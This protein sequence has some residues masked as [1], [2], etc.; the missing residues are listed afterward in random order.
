MAT[1]AARQAR[2]SERAQ[3]ARE[4]W[5]SERRRSAAHARMADTMY[6]STPSAPVVELSCP[7]VTSDDVRRAVLGWGD[8]VSSSPFSS[9][10]SPR[11]TRRRRVPSAAAAR[12]AG[13]FLV[14]RRRRIRGVGLARRVVRYRCD[15]IQLG[16][17]EP[18]GAAVPICLGRCPAR[19]CTGDQPLG[20]VWRG[21]DRRDRRHGCVLR[22]ADT[23]DRR[24]CNGALQ[25][26]RSG[27]RQRGQ[28]SER[29]HGCGP[30]RL[31]PG[32]GQRPGR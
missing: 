17:D 22:T 12:G 7:V 23:V 26:G 9:G 16:H 8:E 20:R 11:R 3:V 15:G 25:L 5:E 29:R 6:A 28:G 1:S 30:G 32:P 24:R 18:P 21:A 31:V 4:R 27:D 10:R 2:E 19:F 14:E 13:E